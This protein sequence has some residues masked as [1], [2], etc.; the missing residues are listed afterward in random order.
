MKNYLVENIKVN[1]SLLE[2]SGEREVI[3]NR[4]NLVEQEVKDFKILK[5]S[6]DARKR[7]KEGIFYV[8]N[9]NFKYKGK[10]HAKHGKVS[11]YNKTDKKLDLT[12]KRDIKPLIIGAGPSGLFAGLY[13]AKMGYEPI[14]FERGE[15]ICDRV[16]TVK[17]FFENG[18]LNEESNVQFGLGGAGTFSDGKINSRIKGDLKYEVLDTL[19]KCGASRNI[20][21]LNKPHLG[22]DKLRM[23]VDDLKALIEYYGGKINFSSKVTDF[24]IENEKIKGVVINNDKEYLSDT[25]ILGIGNGARD[26]FRLLNKSGVKLENKPFAVGY[27]VEHLREDIDKCCY[28][29][30][31]GSKVLGSASYNLTYHDEDSNKGIYSFCNCPGGVVVA[32]ASGKGQVVTNGMSFKKRNMLNSNS[33]IVV[34]VDSS[35]YGENLLDGILFQEKLEN[36]AFNLGGGT[37]AAPYMSIYEYLGLKGSTSVIPS[38]KPYIKE[39]DIN[40]L[41]NDKLNNAIKNSLKHFN[42][43]FDCFYDGIITGVETRT[44]SPVRI[45]R[46][47]KTMES[48]NICGLYPVGEGSGYAGGILSSAVDGIKAAVAINNKH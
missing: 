35:E 30:Y 2:N 10:I 38:Y 29:N 18:N 16:I 21:Y 39:A 17:D 4:L 6:L 33:A 12:K 26:T 11:F 24:I 15:D 32:G 45:L 47:R 34:N 28:S 31:A 7:D 22:T 1:I 23:I 44:S 19:I 3:I 46:D 14:I 25:V 5:K 13:L 41:L 20:R 36:E 42:S 8:Y 43:F 37:Y 9:V 48:V 27:R 40:L